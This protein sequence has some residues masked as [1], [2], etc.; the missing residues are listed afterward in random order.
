MAQLQEKNKK[1]IFDFSDIIEK[2]IDLYRYQLNVLKIIYDT[3]RN[4]L[5]SKENLKDQL[6]LFIHDAGISSFHN[7]TLKD[8]QILDFILYDE[9][10]LSSKNKENNIFLKKIYH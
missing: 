8:E 6:N 9:I 2:Y 3:F 1:Y 4:E 7:G 5:N 10:Y